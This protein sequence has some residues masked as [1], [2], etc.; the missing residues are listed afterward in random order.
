M[1]PLLATPV[2]YLSSFDTFVRER[3]A[4]LFVH[5]IMRGFV[6][7]MRCLGILTYSVKDRETYNQPGQLILANHPSLIDVVFLIGFI[8][9]AD[10][11]IK[12][13]L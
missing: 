4:K 11:V 6:E 9:Q 8:R 1:L 13:S 10:C 7:L 2:I 3:R 5:Y 12:S